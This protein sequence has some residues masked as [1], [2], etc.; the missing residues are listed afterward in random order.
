M[1]T[2]LGISGYECITNMKYRILG[3]RFGYLFGAIVSNFISLWAFPGRCLH[4]V[5][6]SSGTHT[7]TG[8]FAALFSRGFS[9]VLSMCLLGKPPNLIGPL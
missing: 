2:H 3:K 9:E 5:V 1:Y 8:D 4:G 7:V 6:E